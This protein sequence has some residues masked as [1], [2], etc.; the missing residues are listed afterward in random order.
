[1]NFAPAQ[2]SLSQL[3]TTIKGNFSQI[4]SVA[5][6]T[7]G[8]TAQVVN[9]QLNYLKSVAAN[10]TGQ[11]KVTALANFSDLK[12][13]TI[14]YFSQTRE[15]IAQTMT[16][17]VSQTGAGSQSAKQAA[18]TAFHEMAAS[19]QREMASGVLSVGQGNQLIVKELNQALKALGDKQTLS[20]PTILSLS[21]GQLAAVASGQVS[22]GAAASPHATGGL[23]QLGRPGEAGRDSIPLSAGGTNIV[24]APGEQIAVFTRHQQ[25]VA[26]RMLAPVGGL[27]GLFGS[28]STPNYMASGGL[29]GQSPYALP[30]PASYLHAGSVDQGVDY[31]APAGTPEY[32][33]AAGTIA[34]EGI[35]GFG[36]YAPVLHLDKPILGFTNI[37]YGHAGPDVVPVG[38]HVTAGQQISEVG[39]SF[40]GIFGGL[41]NISTGPHIEI[42][43]GPPFSTGAPM[44]G[45]LNSLLA[46]HPAAQAAAGTPGTVGAGAGAG[47]PV[48]IP[49]LAKPAWTGPGGAVG[50]MGQAVISAVLQAAQAKLQAAAG[51]AGGAVAGGVAGVIGKIGSLQDLNHVFPANGG[52]QLSPQ[53]V[54]QIANWAGLPGQI[55]SEIAHGE[56]D[57]EP[58]AVEKP[59][60]SGAQGFGLWQITTGVGNDQMIAGLGGTGAML[61]P[62]VNARAARNLYLQGGLSPWH[63]T[64]Y[65]PSAARG[66]L[67]EMAKGG[68]VPKTIRA[69][70][71]KTTTRTSTP[72]IPAGK[73][74]TTPKG[75]P[76]PRT[77]GVRSPFKADTY[78]NLVAAVPGLAKISGRV[79]AKMNEL[80]AGTG[81]GLMPLI[82]ALSQLSGQTAASTP[83]AFT[84]FGG[85]FHVLPDDLQY[86]NPLLGEM[87]SLG[88]P[89]TI[90]PGMTYTQAWD[91]YKG[92]LESYNGYVAAHGQD[93]TASAWSTTL[94][95]LSQVLQYVGS[96]G[97][98]RMLTGNDLAILKFA[99]PQIAGTPS[100]SL[101]DTNLA[102]NRLALGDLNSVDGLMGMMNAKIGKDSKV[103]AAHQES[104]LDLEQAEAT[105]LANLKAQVQDLQVKKLKQRVLAAQATYTQSM[106]KYDVQQAVGSSRVDL[107]ACKLE[108]SIVSP[109]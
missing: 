37:Y 38:T 32:A 50:A 76:S 93:D 86:L 52:T 95:N 1:M 34:Q 5:K 9:E 71:T 107:Q 22:P 56:S 99:W 75:R 63:G 92:S 57:Y 70:S 35:S 62:L 64:Q 24:A 58:G 79:Q 83:E 105:R 55:F 53:L 85:A 108:Y 61:N 11:A 72:K 18:S 54:A 17:I 27:P 19:I 101:N 47:A 48:T 8:N 51:A 42:G 43:F 16:S 7:F 14:E 3:E 36:G 6:L 39:D 31:P 97:N 100:G 84:Q 94:G 41:P 109:K 106:K 13:G 74:K 73:P 30:L 102:F 78:A 66:L 12:Q 44:L 65:V 104:T 46:G 103:Y 2:S 21:S 23:I 98:H 45:F 81:T 69:G 28:V 68:I 91:A 77:R 60:A 26:N 29:V 67:L 10:S 15:N 88:F 87:Q 82:T 25:A 96:D 59:E 33:I 4:P 49:T 89:V 40:G 20:A 80:G 90:T